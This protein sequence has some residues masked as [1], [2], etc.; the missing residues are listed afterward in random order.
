MNAEKKISEIVICI[1]RDKT[2]VGILKKTVNT[3]IN[4]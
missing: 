2:K 4:K 3:K 1:E